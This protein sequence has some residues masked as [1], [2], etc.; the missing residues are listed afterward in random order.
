MEMPLMGRIEGAA[1]QADAK[2][3]GGAETKARWRQGRT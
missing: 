1:E 3:R 2:R